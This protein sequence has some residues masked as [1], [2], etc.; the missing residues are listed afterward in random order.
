MLLSKN[1]AVASE[2]TRACTQLVKC[3]A[4]GQHRI[5]SHPVKLDTIGE[6]TRQGRDDCRIIGGGLAAERSRQV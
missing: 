2:L 6:L 5:G 1:P 3:N 4:A